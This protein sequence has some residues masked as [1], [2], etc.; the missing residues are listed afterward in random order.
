MQ[1]RGIKL[2]LEIML[3]IFVFFSVKTYLQRDLVQGAAPSVQAR[4]LDGQ[5]IN[6]QSLSDKP[7]LLYFWATWCP[8]CKMQQGTIASIS[9]DHTV[10]SVAM[11]SGSGQEITSYLQEN[12]LGFPVI[13]DVDGTIAHRYGVS[14]VPT[15]FVIDR[16]N[17]IAFTEVGYTTEWGLRFRLWMA[18]K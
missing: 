7:V 14:G 16:N 8:V 6:L 4:S 2:S 10:I 1:I 15:S 5:A 12:K 18:G 9:K 17:N 11:D 3:I 13:A